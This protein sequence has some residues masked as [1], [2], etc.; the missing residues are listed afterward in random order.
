LKLDEFVQKIKEII[1]INDQISEILEKIPNDKALKQISDNAP[2]VGG[3][4]KIVLTVIEKVYEAK[5][6]PQKR[7]PFTIMRILLKSAENS[8]PYAADMKVEEFFGNKGNTDKFE[9]IV[10]ELFDPRYEDN[11][12]LGQDTEK[13]TDL[14]DHPVFT[15]FK[16]LFTKGIEI[17][18]SKHEDNKISI[19]RFLN[20]FD[21]NVQLRLDEERENNQDLENL[22]N[23]WKTYKN[24]QNLQSYLENAS[25]K[26][27]EK[28]MSIDGKSVSEYYVENKAY[29]VPKSTWNQDE[30]NIEKKEEWTIDSLLRSNDKI[31]VIAAPFGIG[32]SSLAKK[33]SYECASKFIQNPTDSSAYIPIF[34][35]LQ[36]A[37]EDTCNNCS[38]QNDLS[39]V[40]S[41][42]SRLENANILAILDGL[43][44]LPDSRPI[45]LYNIYTTL[46]S[47]TNN[48]PNLKVIITTRLEAGFPERLN[49]KKSYVRLFSFNKEQ[50]QRFFENYGIPGDSNSLANML[51]EE[52]LG[53]ALFCWM[54]ATVYNRS[55]EED[56]QIIFDYSRKYNLGEIIIYQR[57]IHDVILG[58]P[59]KIVEEE[60]P[61]WYERSQDE[62]R[63]LRLIAFLKNDMPGLSRDRVNYYLKSL[64]YVVPKSVESLIS[65][66]FATSHDSEGTQRLEFIHESFKE[67]LL[68]EFYL[69]SIFHRKYHRLIGNEPSK[70]TYDH[71]SGLIRLLTSS[72]Q[73]LMK[74][75]E[76]F[77]KTLDGDDGVD[78]I[79]LRDF[80]M[81]FKSNSLEFAK[82]QRMLPEID[83]EE[84][85]IWNFSPL[86]IG[87]LPKIW[88][89]RWL[90]IFIAG[91]LT[92]D[93]APDAGLVKTASM[94]IKNAA[95]LI[96]NRILRST[97]IMNINLQHTQLL[98]VDLSNANLSGA[99]LNGVIFSRMSN[100]STYDD[101]TIKLG[102]LN[103]NL[104]I[105]LW[106]MFHDIWSQYL[107]STLLNANLSYANLSFAEMSGVN[108]SHANLSY[109]N[110]SYANLSDADLSGANLSHANLSNVNLSY[111]NLNESIVLNPENFSQSKFH[112]AKTDR[113][114]TDTPSFM[115][116][117]QKYRSSS[118]MPLYGMTLRTPLLVANKEQLI[119]E[120][121]ARN[122]LTA[123]IES[124]VQA[125]IF[126]T[127]I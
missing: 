26:F 75:A 1:P 52:K 23:K 43:D 121:N 120:L 30:K 39:S 69:E 8:L 76:I 53:K 34:V 73:K 94:V 88:A 29:N 85:S 127:P 104:P 70:E 9:N 77:I 3:I 21:L 57:F 122:V 15:K 81:K 5:V 58:K 100:Y 54:I 61:E 96:N 97:N 28:I 103:L 91:N 19:P 111:A 110:L 116:H 7:L 12:M 67:Y 109:A 46:Q 126:Y 47:Y 66:Y 42:S 63:A 84:N 60:F 98:S 24:F 14:R 112:Q 71:L 2:F 95:S 36:S 38:L 68:A 62:K 113:L 106:E 125:S 51:T 108:L 50:I 40:A 90:A 92:R 33:I 83:R 118:W 20:E 79:N 18:N 119:S 10:L 11:I 101:E 37:L 17:Y 87:D 99:E 86:E 32:K 65:T 16:S 123:Q 56:R 31:A 124:I 59:K 49:I 117:I 55:S 102:A 80:M 35:P 93:E 89:S 105:R 107:N 27:F 74:Y 44:E 82:Q 115:E 22:L 45:N 72:D 4:I 13:I 6:P 114:L 64:H 78:G 48:F 41:Y 25:N